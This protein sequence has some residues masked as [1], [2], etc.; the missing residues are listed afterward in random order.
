MRTEN[1]VMYIG[2]SYAAGVN[3]LGLLYGTG[4]IF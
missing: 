4:A 2:G 3:S 1:F